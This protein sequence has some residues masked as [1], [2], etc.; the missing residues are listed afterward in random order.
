[1]KKFAPSFNFKPSNILF[2]YGLIIFLYR[3]IQ[4]IKDTEYTIPQD[5][6]LII[7]LFYAFR[8]LGQ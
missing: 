2:V 6:I 3:F 8:R 5:L 1:M 7:I 4:D